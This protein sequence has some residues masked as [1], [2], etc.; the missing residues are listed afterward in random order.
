[1]TL[2]SRIRDDLQVP[3]VGASDL[4]TL[5]RQAPDHVVNQIEEALQNADPSEAKTINMNGRSIYGIHREISYGAQFTGMTSEIGVNDRTANVWLDP[6]DLLGSNDS[7]ET[8]SNSDNSDMSRDW[9]DNRV[10]GGLSGL[11][12]DDFDSNGTVDLGSGTQ[13]GEYNVT[14]GGHTVTD[15]QVANSD[16][17]TRTGNDTVAVTGNGQSNQQ[18]GNGAL[19]GVLNGDD[20]MMLVVAVA[21]AAALAWGVSR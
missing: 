17:L 9:D 5:R 1:M 4:P 16:Q 14:P 20:N 3:L 15:E 8:T 2:W 12:D 6:D 19:A 18:S 10:E 7:N 11:D 21:A 13:G